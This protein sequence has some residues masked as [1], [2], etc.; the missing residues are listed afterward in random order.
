MFIGIYYH[1]WE[2]QKKKLS[3]LV[4]EFADTFRKSL[5]H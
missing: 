1:F 4:I 5:V 3:Q 2:D